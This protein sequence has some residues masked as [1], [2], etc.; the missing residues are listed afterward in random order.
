[1]IVPVS[2]TFPDEKTSL[3]LHRNRMQP[4]A[5]FLSFRL[6][7]AGMRSMMMVARCCVFFRERAGEGVLREMAIATAKN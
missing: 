2:E 4:Q 1:M 6:C 3:W 7:V 5:R